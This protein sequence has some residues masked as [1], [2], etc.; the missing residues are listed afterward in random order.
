MSIENWL[1]LIKTTILGMNESQRNMIVDQ[2]EGLVSGNHSVIETKERQEVK[3]TRGRPTIS[4]QKK[5]QKSSSTKRDPSHFEHEEARLRKL[6]KTQAKVETEGR[7]S[8]LDKSKSKG[9][10]VSHDQENSETPVSAQSFDSLS[11]VSSY[12]TNQ[13][14][15]CFVRNQLI[16]GYF[17]MAQALCG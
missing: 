14:Q 7:M 8:N 12:L 3:S 1:D 11:W 4:S 5:K 10:G 13:F 15:F 16:T 17:M 6:E 9:K 2:I